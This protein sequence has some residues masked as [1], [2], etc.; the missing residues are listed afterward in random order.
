MDLPLTSFL[1]SCLYLP[2]QLPNFFLALVPFLEDT[3]PLV[4]KQTPA[5]CVLIAAVQPTG[6]NLPTN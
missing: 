5:L 1:Q 3:I 6:S 2:Q 4:M